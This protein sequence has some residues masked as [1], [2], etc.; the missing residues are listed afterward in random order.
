MPLKQGTAAEGESVLESQISSIT[1]TVKILP[2]A[3]FSKGTMLSDSWPEEGVDPVHGSPWT[4]WFT[5]P[6]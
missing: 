4:S 2:L 3:D 6:G 1:A 5:D